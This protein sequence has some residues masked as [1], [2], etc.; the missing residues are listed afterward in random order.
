MSTFVGPLRL[1][2][3]RMLVCVTEQVSD[4]VAFC[5]RIQQVL[6]SCLVL[7]ESYSR[8]ESWVPP[9]DAAHWWSS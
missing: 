2:F 1:H 7:M 5:T 4:A 3:V 8:S 6:G 9:W